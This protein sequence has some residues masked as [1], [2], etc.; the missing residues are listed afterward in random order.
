MFASFGA[1]GEY[2]I[3]LGLRDNYYTLPKKKLSTVEI[4]IHSLD[5]AESISQMLYCIL[6]T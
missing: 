5:S 6:F 3:E 4:F 1:Y 2:G